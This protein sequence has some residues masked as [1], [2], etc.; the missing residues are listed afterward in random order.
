MASQSDALVAV[1]TLIEAAAKGVEASGV[2]ATN[3]AA[4]A[5]DLALAYRYAAGGQ[6][7]GGVTIEKG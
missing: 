7:P 5:R 2:H 3:K 4:A 6:Q 1:W